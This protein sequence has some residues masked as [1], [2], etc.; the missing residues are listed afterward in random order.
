ML[1]GDE[2]PASTITIY[3]YCMYLGL[4]LVE[5]KLFTERIV[6]I[7]NSLD[8]QASKHERTVTASTLN[9]FKRNLEYLRNSTKMC[10]I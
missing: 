8:E 1:V 9:R 10:L 4:L 7:W 2:L 3:M 5:R 6:N